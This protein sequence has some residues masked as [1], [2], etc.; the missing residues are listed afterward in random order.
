M[1]GDALM[2]KWS[3]LHAEKMDTKDLLMKKRK[4]LIIDDSELN[5]GIL[6]DML[7]DKYE[8]LEACDGEEGI[9]GIEKH[10]AEIAIVLLDLV[11]PKVDGFDVLKYMNREEL[12]HK[13]P[14]ITISSENNPESMH[15][16]FELGSTDYITRPYD[17]SIVK[18]RIH[19]TIMLYAKQKKLIDIVAEQIYEKEKNNDLMINIL[20]HI[21]EFR[22]GE[23]GLHVIHIQVITEILLKHLIQKTDRYALTA[24]DIAMITS[25]SALHD[26]G[27]ISIP[28]EI[29]N[30]PGRFT[31]E[32]FAVMKT[33]SAAGA[34]LLSQI[35]M[36]RDEPLIKVANEI[37]R[38]HH[39]RYDGRGYPDGLK[40]DAIPIS[41]QIVSIADV[42]DALTSERCYK[43][44]YS[45]EKSIEMIMNGECGQFNPMLLECLTECSEQIRAALEG[46]IGGKRDKVSISKEAESLTQEVLKKQ[47]IV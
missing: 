40:G 29:L 43:K 36:Y 12:I 35:E 19:N 18:N 14:V 5:R 16:S 22:N 21:V 25:A 23:S 39:E 10:Q 8:V 37:C 41:A 32:E 24:S 13:I 26:I 7:C 30:K 28:D 46:E 4:V 1:C 11:M 6:A 3:A 45:H 31:P 33:H 2:L 47:N 34:K 42:Y 27:K 20:S 15:R 9:A 44:A 38:W 17:E